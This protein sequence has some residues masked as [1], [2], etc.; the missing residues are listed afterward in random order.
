M[1]NKAV[2]KISSPASG[3]LIVPPIQNKNKNEIMLFFFFFLFFF[4]RT[5]KEDRGKC[6][7]EKIEMF[8]RCEEKEWEKGA[9]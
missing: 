7:E 6:R 2:V 1:R 8:Y 9:N 3:R 4:K 5:E